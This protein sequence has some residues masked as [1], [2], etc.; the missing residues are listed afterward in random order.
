MTLHGTRQLPISVKGRKTDMRTQF[1]ALCWRVK[2]GKPQILLITSRGTKNWIIPKGWPMSGI[3]P[4]EGAAQEAWEEAG[5]KGKPFDR[6]L[7]LFSYMKK[8]DKRKSVPTVAMVFPV[9]VKKLA[10]DFPEA[11][12]RKRKWVSPKKASAMVRERELAH[13]LR[14]FDP[15]HL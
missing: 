15:R 4:S 10:K 12:Q 9:K 3:T 1:A 13:I 14:T 7:G 2:N 11:G 6:S 8:I 5:V